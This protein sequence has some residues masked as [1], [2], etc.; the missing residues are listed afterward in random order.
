M[1]NRKNRAIWMVVGGFLLLNAIG[2]T[3]AMVGMATDDETPAQATTAPEIVATPKKQAPIPTS[4]PIRIRVRVTAT[5]AQE[6]QYASPLLRD[7]ELHQ[8]SW[9]VM[10]SVHPA[11]NR[12]KCKAAIAVSH[13]YM[14][15]EESDDVVDQVTVTMRSDLRELYAEEAFKHLEYGFVSVSDFARD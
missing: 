13:I 7:L 15:M 10:H 11:R 2:F 6:E 14:A 4:T 8:A 12:E 9:R 5:P 3:I 1:I